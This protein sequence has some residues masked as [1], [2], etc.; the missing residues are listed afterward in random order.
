MCSGI[1]CTLLYGAL[2]FFVLADILSDG[3]DCD[4]CNWRDRWIWYGQNA[5]DGNVPCD[6]CADCTGILA[7]Q[8]KYCTIIKRNR[9]QGLSEQIKNKERLN[10]GANGKSKCTGSWK[11]GNGPFTAPAQKRTSGKTVVR[12]LENEVKMLNEKRE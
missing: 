9:K 1:F 3:A 11:L 10:G 4:D 8:S 12:A 5:Y 2:C 6:G 7:S